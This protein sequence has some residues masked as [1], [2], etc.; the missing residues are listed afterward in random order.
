MDESPKHLN[1]RTRKRYRDDRPD[2][3]TIYEN[4]LRWLFTAQQNSLQQSSSCPMDEDS[5]M[6]SDVLP[7]PET[8]DPR[9]QTLHKFFQPSQSSLP[10]PRQN[11][12]E[13]NKPI[14]MSFPQLQ[15]FDM[16]LM[17]ATLTGDVTSPSSRGN[18]PNMG[19]NIDFG[20]DQ[21][22]QEPK[23]CARPMGWI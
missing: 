15:R 7:L 16:G 11:H 13:T 10:Q 22:A 17:A 19:M 5:G 12:T 20:S 4:T 14:N 23:G 9:Q 21:S 3:K 1:C 18:Y 2:D 6:N 8:V